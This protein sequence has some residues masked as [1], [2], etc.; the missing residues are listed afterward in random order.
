[1]LNDDDR[2]LL[3]EFLGECWHDDP[4]P[5]SPHFLF[6]KLE[7]SKCHGHYLKNRTFATWQDTGDLKV[8]IVEMGEWEGFIYF[9]CRRWPNRN[10]LSW[11][12]LRNWL[13]DPIRFPELVAGWLKER[14]T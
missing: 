9:I 14:R 2:K 7:C 8:K 3:T 13:M 4:T 10:D 12:E 11:T 5:I 1:M 6:V